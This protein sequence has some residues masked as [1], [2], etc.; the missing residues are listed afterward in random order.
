MQQH[1][2]TEMSCP[3]PA[4]WNVGVAAARMEH[5]CRELRSDGNS[6]A[7]NESKSRQT[8]SS[9]GEDVFRN[10]IVCNWSRAASNLIKQTKSRPMEKKSKPWHHYLIS[11]GCSTLTA[12][13]NKELKIENSSPVSGNPRKGKTLAKLPNWRFLWGDQIDWWQR[14][15]VTYP[16]MKTPQ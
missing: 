9:S 7:S 3:C 15:L 2:T 8:I 11:H 14:Y 10:G 12:N 6:M 4:P 16:T 1:Y 5:I 13:T